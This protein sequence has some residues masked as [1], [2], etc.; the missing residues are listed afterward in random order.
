MAT[1]VS[2]SLVWLASCQ[3]ADLLRFQT[4]LEPMLLGPAAF[5]SQPASLQLMGCQ[6]AHGKNRKGRR[7]GRKEARK[8]RR[9]EGRNISC[10]AC[11]T[12]LGLLYSSRNFEGLAV[13]LLLPLPSSFN[14]LSVRPSVFLSNVWIQ[15]PQNKLMF[16][17]G[18][19]WLE[20]I[21]KLDSTTT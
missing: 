20:P 10:L 21:G 18:Y 12:H 19:S 5:S 15:L 2:R 11:K 16:I 6:L 9:K 1:E 3:S 4:S 8:E 17:V 13:L 7:T 14:C